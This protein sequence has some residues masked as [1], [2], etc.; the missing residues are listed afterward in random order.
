MKAETSTNFP[1]GFDG[2]ESP[3]EIVRLAKDLPWDEFCPELDG[4]VLRDALLKSEARHGVSEAHRAISEH[5]REHLILRHNFAH[6]AQID[7]HALSPSGRWLVTVNGMGNELEHG[8]NLQVWEVESGRVVNQLRVLQG[9]RNQK[10][11]PAIVWSPNNMELAL[12]HADTGVGIWRPFED[13]GEP[14][15]VASFTDFGIQPGIRF[16][17]GGK[18]LE[19]NSDPAGEDDWDMEWDY[20]DD[21]DP[22]RYDYDYLDSPEHTE[23]QLDVAPPEVDDWEV[24][25][26]HLEGGPQTSVFC[27]RDVWDEDEQSGMPILLEECTPG[28]DFV[29]LPLFPYEHQGEPGWGMLEDGCVVAPDDLDLE[30]YLNYSLAGWW[31]WPLRWCDPIRN[32]DLDEVDAYGWPKPE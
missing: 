17:N 6:E 31:V 15:A 18:T 7:G 4:Q 16:I 26:P 5:V 24:R 22:P 1:L 29:V 28:G 2:S 27:L 10:R 20:R 3:E 25:F 21:V 14:L 32:E 8:A 19:I 13:E 12:I 11:Y 23:N 30:P 9:V